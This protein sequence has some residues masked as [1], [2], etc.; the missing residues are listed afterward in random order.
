MRRRFSVQD[1]CLITNTF[2]LAGGK[3]SAKQRKLRYNR[4][5]RSG[6]L[7]AAAPVLARP[8]KCVGAPINCEIGETKRL[9]DLDWND[10]SLHPAALSKPSELILRGQ[11]PYWFRGNSS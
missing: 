2:P 4:R 8:P 9:S 5:N 3:L 1:A 7:C 11:H 6:R 10:P